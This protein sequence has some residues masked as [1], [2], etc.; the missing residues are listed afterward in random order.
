MYNH[1][2]SADPAKRMAAA[3]RLKSL[4]YDRALQ[5]GVAPGDE[6]FSKKTGKSAAGGRD[7]YFNDAMARHSAKQSPAGK[8]Q[9]IQPPS[10]GTPYQSGQQ[11]GFKYDKDPT[12][13]NSEFQN[14][15]DV[16]APARTT[17]YDRAANERMYDQ[18]LAEKGKTPAPGVTNS[19]PW[20]QR[21]WQVR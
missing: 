2:Q 17:L 7:Q 9:S 20:S 15:L 4:I 12:L 5:Q 8:A 1:Y 13:G 19:P 10:Q 11:S 14:W 16:K 3:E 6:W 18:F 21:P